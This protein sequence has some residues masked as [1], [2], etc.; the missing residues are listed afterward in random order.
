MSENTENLETGLSA[1]ANGATGRRGQPLR[2][3]SIG[4]HPADVFDQS[5][6]RPP[7]RC[8]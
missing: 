4:A 1:P 5:G 6:G 7:R 3:L 8:L 2:L